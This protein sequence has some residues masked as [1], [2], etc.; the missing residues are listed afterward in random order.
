[1][2]M[3]VENHLHMIPIKQHSQKTTSFTLAEHHTCKEIPTPIRRHDFSHPQ[4]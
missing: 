3:R 4:D 1:M 2:Q